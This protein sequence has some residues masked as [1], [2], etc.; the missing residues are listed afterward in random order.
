MTA[1]KW[2]G[3]PLAALA[4]VAASGLTAISMLVSADS[5]REQAKAEIR[6]ATGLDPIFRGPSTVSLFPFGTITFEDVSLGEG[7]QTA[8]TAQRLTAS[9]R[10]FPLLIGHVETGEIRLERPT[11]T[12]NLGDDGRSNWTQLLNSLGH[13]Q[14]SAGPTPP[15]FSAIRID[16]G[17]VILRDHVHNI[18]EQFDRV[19]LSL[20]WP[21][22]SSSFGATGQFQWH[23]QPIDVSVTLADFT[24][25]LA[26]KT[27]GLKL[28]M[29]GAPGKIAFDGS[30]GTQPTLKVAGTLV[31]DSPSLRKALTW[32]GQQPLPG[33]G[34]ERFA[35]KADASVVGGTIAL[36]GVNIEL[37]K[38][39]AEGVLAF[40][41]DGRR[42]LQGT[43]AADSLDLRPYT[44][45][46][47]FVS[48]NQR[49][50]N[51][52]R[53]SLDGMSSFDVDLRLSA[54]NVVLADAKLGRTAVSANLRDGDLSMTIGESQAFGGTI[55]GTIVLANVM[56]GI[57]VKSE[58]HFAD[59]DL[60]TCLNQLF[61][62]RRLEGKGN[63]ELAVEGKG[64][65]I[66]AVTRTLNGTATLSGS[67]GALVGLNVEQLL[68]RLERR[69]LS[70]GS[71]LH[72]G[73]TPYKN[74]AISLKIVN[75]KVAVD[76][77]KIDGPAV[78][79]AVAGSASIPARNLDLT[80]TAVLLSP[81]TNTGFELPFVVQGSWD[82]P[83]VLPDAQILIRRSGAAAPLLNAV[84]NRRSQDA[85]RSTI[86]KLTGQPL[87]PAAEEAPKAQQ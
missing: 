83:V 10:F 72:T 47:H 54:G 24:A 17:K 16:D 65:S 46:I 21:S 59:V 15:S 13:S 31:A 30:I 60:D 50:W 79:V 56:K 26:G 6:E 1:L 34:F 73:R 35:L 85:V 77:V 43:L 23:D 57:D 18:V 78:R 66:L 42:T 68:K 11:I 27:S 32:A 44:S 80:G 14:L 5:A 29:G 41:V 49:E 82:D 22:I 40:A 87:P 19:A 75:G 69:P 58:L 53:V 63:I 39:R 8:L 28:R 48:N 4:F 37:D 67:S 7:R 74:V 51:D 20:A 62:I 36:S 70:A 3:L 45:A 76:D 2:L 81:N 86:E 52:G 9:L 61:D 25:A 12:V 38:N 64:D 33:A 55:K 71:E 84:R